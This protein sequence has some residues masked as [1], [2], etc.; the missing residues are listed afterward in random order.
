[1]EY[2]K[3]PLWNIKKSFME[4]KKKIQMVFLL[5]KIWGKN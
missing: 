1:M 3:I 2:K 4:C 5:C